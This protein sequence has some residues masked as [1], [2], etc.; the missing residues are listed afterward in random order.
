MRSAIIRSRPI[1]RYRI[2]NIYIFIDLH[3]TQWISLVNVNE[4]DWLT[5]SKFSLSPSLSTFSWNNQFQ[6]HLRCKTKAEPQNQL[7]KSVSVFNNPNLCWQEEKNTSRLEWIVSFWQYQEDSTRHTSRFSTKH[8]HTHTD[9]LHLTLQLD[10]MFRNIH[11]QR[12]NLHRK[13]YRIKDDISNRDDYF[14]VDVLWHMKRR[15]DVRRE[16]E[17]ERRGEERR[18][19]E[20]RKPKTI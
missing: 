18:G 7:E 19:D 5:Y 15:E 9:R 1:H 8:T 13:E 6:W 3:N 20:E 11:T 17:R 10:S 2:Y 12:E 14:R 16:R 4:W